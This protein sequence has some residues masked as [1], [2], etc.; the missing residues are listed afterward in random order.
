LKTKESI[1]SVFL[2]E[3]YIY[4][5]EGTQLGIY[6]FPTRSETTDSV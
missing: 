2:D 1:H 5:A 6:R 3:K 4:T